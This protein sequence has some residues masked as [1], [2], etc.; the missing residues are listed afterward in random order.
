MFRS[1]VVVEQHLFL[2]IPEPFSAFPV[3]NLTKRNV[4]SGASK[5]RTLLQN[6]EK[7]QLNSS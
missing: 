2:P 5:F 4:H 7:N 1:V 3:F 6:A